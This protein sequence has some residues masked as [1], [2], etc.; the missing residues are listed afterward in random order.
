L[1]AAVIVLIQI[2]DHLQKPGWRS[3]MRNAVTT[4]DLPGFLLFAPA[5]IQ[6]FLALQYGGNQF[7]WNS[8]QVIGLF[9]GAAATFILWLLW[10]YYQGDNTMV[11]FSMMRK[12]IVWACCIC[13]SF[14]GS[15]IFVTA[16]YLPIYFQ[17]VRAHSPF[18]SGVDVLP[19]ILTQ[20][21]FSVFAGM[22]SRL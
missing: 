22:L 6:F 21:V 9:C 5:A 14:F 19:G 8:S 18:H 7:A 4:F 2:P 16:Y 13:G 12:R 10:D 3:V 17:S 15:T 20:M 1:I 11:P